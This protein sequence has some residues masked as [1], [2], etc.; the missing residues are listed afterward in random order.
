MPMGDRCKSSVVLLELAWRPSGLA[1]EHFSIF[2]GYV[3]LISNSENFNVRKLLESRVKTIE[4]EVSNAK[5]TKTKVS[6][7][8]FRESRIS[9]ESTLN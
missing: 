4:I 5:D 3:S 1:C 8:L 9:I 6:R 7:L 2:C